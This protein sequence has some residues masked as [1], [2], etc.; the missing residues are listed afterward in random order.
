MEIVASKLC[1]IDGAATSPDQA[2]EGPNRS[3]LALASLAHAHGDAV[4]NSFAPGWR[5]GKHP[6]ETSLDRISHG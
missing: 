3:G 1:E 5:N 6:A 4:F 2:R